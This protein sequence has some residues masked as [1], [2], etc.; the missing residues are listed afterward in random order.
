[1]SLFKRRNKRAPERVCD[2][3]G[4]NR[5]WQVLVG[6]KTPGRYLCWFHYDAVEHAANGP[7]ETRGGAA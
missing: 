1:M 6:G 7:Y 2:H 5:P 3:I 4:C